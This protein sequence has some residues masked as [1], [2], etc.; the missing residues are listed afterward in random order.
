[1]VPGDY[2]TVYAEEDK[3][4]YGEVVAVADDTIDVYYI[5][6]ARQ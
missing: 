6:R 5:E 3:I 4:W 1:M 2:V